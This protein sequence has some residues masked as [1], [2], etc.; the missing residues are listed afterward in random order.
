MG[1]DGE[2]IVLGLGG[3]VGGDAA[4]LARFAAVVRSF[5]SWSTVRASRVYRTAPLGPA[6]PDYLNAAIAVEAPDELAASELLREVQA[7]EQAFGRRRAAETRNGPRP[8][9]VD[10]LLWGARTLDFGKGKLIVP[11]P[12]LAVRGFALQP[13]IDLLGAATPHPSEHRTFGE[14]LAATA[15][16]RVELTAYTIDGAV[17]AAP[18]GDG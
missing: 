15:D 6:Q 5:E 11:H 7:V 16:Q 8:I 9:D 12:R 17:T 13:V 2:T 3:N 10:V 1:L 14:L 4:V 18:P